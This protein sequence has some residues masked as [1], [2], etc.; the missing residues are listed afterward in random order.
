MKTIERNMAVLYIDEPTILNDYK[1][2]PM[3]INWSCCGSV[4]VD[5]AEEFAKGILE[6]V[7]V[8]RE[9]QAAEAGKEGS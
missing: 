8:A 3:E 7:A 2:K 1:P 9:L 5:T 6:L 4:Q